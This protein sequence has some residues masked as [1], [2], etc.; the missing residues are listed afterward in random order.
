MKIKLQQNVYE[1]FQG[2]KS[3][4]FIGDIGEFLKIKSLSYRATCTA[5]GP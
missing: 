4:A 3:D 1:F 2:W 5:L